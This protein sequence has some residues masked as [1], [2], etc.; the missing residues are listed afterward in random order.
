MQETA[1][2]LP[3][4]AIVVDYQ[5]GTCLNLPP[6]EP[7]IAGPCSST[8]YVQRMSEDAEPTPRGREAVDRVEVALLLG[9]L[10]FLAAVTFK[11]VL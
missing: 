1:Q 11:Y 5:N 8:C 3:K 6:R 4:V 2:Q 9:C 7:S 10:L